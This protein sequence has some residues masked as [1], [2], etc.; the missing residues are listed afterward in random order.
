MNEPRAERQ[1]GGLLLRRVRRERPDRTAVLAA[2]VLHL[3][4][5]GA[6]WVTARALAADTPEYVVYRV[7]LVSPPPQVEGEPEPEP[8]VPEP[9]KI[10]APEPE[11]TPPEPRPQPKQPE[12]K[13]PAPAQPS[14]PPRTEPKP[15]EPTRGRSAQATSTGG[16][17]LNVQLQGEQCPS[18]GYCENIIRQVNRFFRWTGTGRPRTEVAFVILRDG[19]VENI[20][21]I[22]ASGNLEFDFKA[23]AAIE[24]AGKRRAFGALPAGWEVDHLPISFYFEPPQ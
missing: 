9:P 24:E 8:P 21:V 16:E 18:P 7:N 20:R 3:S 1:R 10:A 23:M 4:A 2:L 14:T 5:A 22:R 6:L 12:A 17:G 19:S 13:K 15:A 11:P